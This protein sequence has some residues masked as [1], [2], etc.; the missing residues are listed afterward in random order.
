MTRAAQR[1]MLSAN[2]PS[3]CGSRT[4]AL[5]C[6]AKL[7]KKPR[8]PES[9]HSPRA[10]GCE[11]A[12]FL[13]RERLAPICSDERMT[14]LEWALKSSF[15]GALTSV[16]DASGC[17]P[18]NVRFLCGVPHFASACCVRESVWILAT[19]SVNCAFTVSVRVSLFRLQIKK[20]ISKC[21]PA[22]LANALHDSAAPSSRCAVW[23]GS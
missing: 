15:R 13:L 9:G 19:F 16:A 3:M 1:L 23:G 2:R 11:G 22:F 18:G 20:V 12:V 5:S 6:L 8:A 7:P 17:G 14:L 21:S 10:E 4:R